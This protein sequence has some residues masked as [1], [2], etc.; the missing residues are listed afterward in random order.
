MSRRRPFA[1][2]AACGVR[3]QLCLYSTSSLRYSTKVELYMYLLCVLRVTQPARHFRRCAAA[4]P[5]ARS[6]KRAVSPSRHPHALT[7][8]DPPPRQPFPPAHTARANGVAAGDDPRQAAT[9]RSTHACRASPAPSCQYATLP[10]LASTP[11][12]IAAL[13]TSRICRHQQRRQQQQRQHHG[14]LWQQP[15]WQCASTE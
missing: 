10:M 13:S 3:S 11:R 9:W 12:R 7:A 4:L 14:G 1:S 5:P 2:S 8:G 6:A 15:P